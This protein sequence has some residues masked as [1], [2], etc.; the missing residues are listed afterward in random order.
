MIGRNGKRDADSI[1]MEAQLGYRG[2]KG[3]MLNLFEQF[4][5]FCSLCQGFSFFFIDRKHFL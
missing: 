2:R 5:N 4:L 1:K 3:S